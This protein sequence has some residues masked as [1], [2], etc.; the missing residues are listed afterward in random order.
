M[1]YSVAETRRAPASA[2]LLTPLPLLGG[3]RVD[4]E[5]EEEEG[6]GGLEPSCPPNPYQMH[7]PPEGCC[8]TD[9]EPAGPCRPLPA[10]PTAQSAAC[11][12]W[13][14]VPV[15]PPYLQHWPPHSVGLHLAHSPSATRGSLDWRVL[16]LTRW[17][18]AA[19]AQD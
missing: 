6:E 3:S 7:P 18:F 10:V 15:R 17:E 12:V 14:P 1:N 13:S 8:T 2:S 16:D 5:E 9:G 11:A 4:N 19:L